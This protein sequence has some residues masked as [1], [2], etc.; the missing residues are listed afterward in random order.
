MCQWHCQVSS[1]KS[2][3]VRKPPIIRYHRHHTGK[4]GR[5]RR[6]KKKVWLL[7]GQVGHYAALLHRQTG[8]APLIVLDANVIQSDTILSENQYREAQKQV[9]AEL[10]LLG[11]VI[12]GLD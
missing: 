3:R 9:T 11:N 10:E 8:F 4:Q 1:R 7:C 12:V 5:Q 2:Q 6:T